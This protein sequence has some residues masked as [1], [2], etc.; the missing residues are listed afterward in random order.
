[1]LFY[2]GSPKKLTQHLKQNDMRDGETDKSWRSAV[3]S[4][5]LYYLFTKHLFLLSLGNSLVHFG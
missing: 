5:R 1:M 2:Y 3:T 4:G